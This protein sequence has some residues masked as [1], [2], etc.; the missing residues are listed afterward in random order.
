MVVIPLYGLCYLYD[1]WSKP[2]KSQPCWH[3]TTELMEAQV[4]TQS[5]KLTDTLARE[6]D[7]LHRLGRDQEAIPLQKRVASLQ[8]AQMN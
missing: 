5:P 8:A 4:G 2:E 3:R 7:A 1:Q 6:A